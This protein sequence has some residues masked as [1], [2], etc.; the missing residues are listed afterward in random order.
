[1]AKYIEHKAFVDFMIARGF[2]PTLVA[3]AIEDMPAA[4]VVEVVRCR[5]CKY[6]RESESVCMFHFSK[7]QNHAFCSYGERREG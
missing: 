6:H 5:D 4:D 1:M 7:V 2:Y 3:R